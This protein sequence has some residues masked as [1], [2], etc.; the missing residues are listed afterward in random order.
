MSHQIKKAAFSLIEIIIAVALFSVFAVVFLTAATGPSFDTSNSND[1]LVARYLVQEAQEGLRSVK[2]Y[3]WENLNI[4]AGSTGTSGP[5]ALDTSNGYWEIAG[6]ENTYGKFTRSFELEKFSDYR[7]EAQIIVDWETAYGVPQSTSSRIRFT[8]WTSLAWITDTE[9]DFLNGF[10]NSVEVLAEGSVKL[11]DVASWASPSIFATDYSG[12]GDLQEMFKVKNLLYLLFNN[13]TG[14]E[15]VVYDTSDVSN[16]SL[17]LVG[18]V[19]LGD[20]NFDFVIDGDYAYIASSA[21]NSEVKI[22]DL[23]NFTEV[24]T[25]NLDG[26]ADAMGLAIEG[27]TLVVVRTES[28]DPE[29]YAID[30]SNPLSIDLLTAITADTISNLNDVEMHNGNAFVVSSDDST[31]LMIFDPSD[32]SELS[33]LDLAES[34]D[35]LSIHIDPSAEMA[36][37]GKSGSVGAEFFAVDVSNTSLNAGDIQGSTNTQS[38]AVNDI[39]VYEGYAYLASSGGTDE[40]EIVD[41]S[42]YSLETAVDL[43]GTESATSVWVQGAH[44]YVGG[45]NASNELQILTS[46][47]GGGTSLSIVG[48]A[49]PGGTQDAYDM[50]LV[51][52]TLYMVRASAG[53]CNSLTGDGCEFLIYDVSTPTSPSLLGALEIGSSA[54]SIY[55]NGDYAYIATDDNTAELKVINVSV[56]LAPLL[57]GSY[58][59]DSNSN[60]EAVWGSGDYVYLGTAKDNGK[61]N[62]SNGNNCEFYVLDI[63]L[64]GSPIVPLYTGGFEANATIFDITSEG[65]YVFMG[66]DSNSAE[67]IILDLSSPTSPAVTTGSPYAHPGG[68]DAHD[69]VYNSNDDT[70][71]VV[72]DN[73]GGNGEYSIIDMSDVSSPTLLGTY[74]HSGALQGVSI[75]SANNKAY[76]VGDV[77]TQELLIMNISNTS[78]PILSHTLDL[79]GIAWAVQNDGSNVFVASAADAQELQVIAE[80]TI[81]VT[82]TTS[83]YGIYTSKKFDSSSPSA[84]WQEIEWVSSGSGT[85]QFQV[86]TASTE[87]GLDTATW[88]GPSGSES[89]YYT[90]SGSTI[91][92]DAGASGTQWVQFAAYFEGNGSAT[93]ILESVTLS[94]N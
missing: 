94:Y 54:N 70:L 25:L 43:N 9:N 18:G 21:N 86:R 49:N 48:T 11:T 83:L 74:D 2:N 79:G 29:I 28:A 61:C 80:E 59:A 34:A 73:N 44:I 58:D 6:T 30:I 19:S 22:V 76:L 10:L 40:L 60:G 93:P 36:Y 31:E 46:D 57:V 8:N 33:T 32:L 87:A 15:F 26:N 41:L 7:Y 16:N 81:V 69:L 77:S 92:T 85:L 1:R 78:L 55:V 45:T 89:A 53:I 72:F 39:F 82:T 5:H 38:G 66:T 68:G 24:N 47:T 12:N 67:I 20:N 50:A 56:P 35:A 65:V 88:V 27:D 64:S 91:Q 52:S 14:D 13:T 71:H 4:I 51:G 3:D 37:I 84:S 90:T 23:T 63:G 62:N 42:N 75:D 17:S